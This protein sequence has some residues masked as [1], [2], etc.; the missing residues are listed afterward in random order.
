MWQE[1]MV[2]IRK[3]LLLEWKQKYAFNGLLLYVISMTVVIALAFRD[4]LTPVSWNIMLWLMLLFAAINA[5]A[6]SFMAEKP[7]QLRYLYTLARPQAIILAKFLYNAVLLVM[8]ALIS[9]LVFAFLGEQEF[10]HGGE[11]LGLVAMGAIALAA[12][13]SLVTA[14]AAKADQ[15]STLLAVLSFPIIVPI[16]LLLIRLSESALTGLADPNQ[17]EFLLFLSG[18]ILVLL[19]V[20]LV[21]FPFLWRE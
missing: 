13:L 14:I 19:L 11:Y 7:E 15:Q 3:E 18:L 1:V 5:V 21:L 17:G 6:K 10:A 8:V 12:N 16:L 9:L 4:S 20:S 2:L